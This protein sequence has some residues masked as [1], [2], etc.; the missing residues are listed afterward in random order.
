[1]VLSG[2]KS[3]IIAIIQARMGSSRFPGKMLTPLNGAPLIDWVVKRTKKAEK[4][5][6]LIVAIPDSE[7]SNELDNHLRDI[8]A[9][10]IRG[11]EN[12]VLARFH[13]AATTFKASH[14][15]RIC[16]DNPMI[17]PNA[18]DELIM[19][20]FKHDPTPDYAYNHVPDGNSW[21]DGLGAE[22]CTIEVLSQIHKEASDPEHREHIFNYLRNKPDR[23]RI[24]TFDPT[25]T[26]LSRPELKLDIDY[27]ENLADLSEIPITPE[28]DTHSLIMHISK[29]STKRN[30]QR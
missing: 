18:I 2:T 25:D 12:D 8:D 13:H 22:I 24:K 14:V 16:G 26:R 15:I 17:C 4:I 11:P 19:F 20:F 9:K 5:D 1:M 28:S 7:P 6:D 10:V 3:M 21:P 30:T 27:P 23:F 29:L